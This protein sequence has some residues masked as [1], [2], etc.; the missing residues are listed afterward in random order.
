MNFYLSSYR[1]GNQTPRLK[2]L[3]AGKTLGFIP[4][5]R[6]HLGREERAAS[7]A[8]AIQEV[9]KLGISVETVDLKTYFADNNGLEKKLK[10]LGGVWVPGG[11]T[12]VLRQA[13]RLSGFDDL[14][15]GWPDEDFLYSGYSAGV[16]VLAPRLD[17]LK[18]VDDSA[19]SPY[20]GSATA[21]AGLGVLDYLILPHY[22]SDHS[23]S[24]DI[25][26]AVSFCEKERIPF[27][28]L[29]DGEVIILDDHK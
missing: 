9:S 22:R 7:T 16:C 26:R 23:E 18:F 28:T 10:S 29:R 21:W 13:M 5:A 27:K 1:L 25:D 2:E 3:A 15:T 4:N 8:L 20:P 19:V 24:D 6:D 17:A 14:L 11:N 12:F